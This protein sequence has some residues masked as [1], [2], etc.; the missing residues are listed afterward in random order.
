M[1]SYRSFQITRSVEKPF[2]QLRLDASAQTGGRVTNSEL[3]HAL[4]LM[5]RDAEQAGPPEGPGWLAI[6]LSAG[7]KAEAE[8]GDAD[9]DTE[10]T[11][12]PSSGDPLR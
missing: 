9:D 6:Y 12:G 3:L 7:R 1:P 4:V 5:A 8:W 10:P 11:T 2:R